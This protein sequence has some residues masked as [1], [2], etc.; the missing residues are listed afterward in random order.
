MGSDVLADRRP[1]AKKLGEKDRDA[2]QRFD[3]LPV[4][5]LKRARDCN[6]RTVGNT[7]SRWRT[8]SVLR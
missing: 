1:T 3:R 8:A 2:G 6:A 5:S 4:K 7:P